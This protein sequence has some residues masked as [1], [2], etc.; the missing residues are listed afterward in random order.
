R[1]SY[2]LRAWRR[3]RIAWARPGSTPVADDPLAVR[4]AFAASGADALAW[5]GVLVSRPLIDGGVSGGLR[6]AAGP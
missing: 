5:Y 4:A 2:S 1:V 6:G 3:G